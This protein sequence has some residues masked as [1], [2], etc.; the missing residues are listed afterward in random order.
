MKLQ[1]EQDRKI[2]KMIGKFWCLG[3]GP[4]IILAG[5]AAAVTAATFLLV[6]DNPFKDKEQNQQGK[7]K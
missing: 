7:P 6:D 2:T 1:K 3:T 4:V 5:V